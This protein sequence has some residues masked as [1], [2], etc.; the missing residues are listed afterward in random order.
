MPSH[1][2]PSTLADDQVRDLVD[3]VLAGTD[4]GGDGDDPVY[5]NRGKTVYRT[6]TEGM[7]CVVKLFERRGPR[8]MAQRLRGRLNIH[9]EVAALERLAP[10]SVTVPALLGRARLRRE[11]A[12]YSDAL[13]LSD[14]GD[15]DGL[16]LTYWATL[17]EPGDHT[18]RFDAYEQA[19]V[20]LTTTMIDAGVLDRDHSMLNIVDLADG[21]LARIDFEVARCVPQGHRE[22]A[23]VGAM[24]GRL[25]GTFVYATQDID[26]ERVQ[27]FSASLFD[28]VRP[29]EA[30]IDETLAV[31]R[32]MMDK[33][34]QAEDIHVELSAAAGGG[35][36]AQRRP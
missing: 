6:S 33:Q 12:P 27:A 10:T 20:A 11:H 21:T 24:L 15:V 30:T 13:V 8:A 26:I 7:S 31:S 5:A 18:A 9:N 2:A 34:R 16:I 35:V 14:L 17:D 1:A 22:P 19:V 23:L 25:I 4:E 36:H 3:Q 32:N 29:D 28:A